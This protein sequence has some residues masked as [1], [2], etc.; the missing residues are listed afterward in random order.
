MNDACV[1]ARN[2]TASATSPGSPIRPNAAV[3]AS[4]ACVA[5]SSIGVAI[6]P[7]NTAL[8]RMPDGASS[9]ATAWVSPR[10]AH[11]DEPYAVWLG[12]GRIAPVLHVLT[13]A[14]PSAARRCVRVDRI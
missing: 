11:L 12:N 10:S 9:A 8:T 6:G 2:A 14:A 7:G 13:M 5:S 4:L 1:D 3:P